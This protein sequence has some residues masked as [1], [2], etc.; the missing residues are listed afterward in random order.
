M[1][2]CMNV[3]VQYSVSLCLYMSLLH[4]Y[5]W[6]VGGG[7]WGGGREWGELFGGRHGCFDFKVGIMS[8]A[9][10]SSDRSR[11]AEMKTVAFQSFSLTPPPST[12][13]SPRFVSS[14]GASVIVICMC[15]CV[16][17]WR[18]R[19]RYHE[20]KVGQKSQAVYIYE[21]SS[22]CASFH[23]SPYSP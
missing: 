19:G 21:I 17:V 1:C 12:S 16:C 10:S 15:V 9:L 20:H 7:G 13:P 2:L 8:A 22:W 4:T 14:H 3:C 5:V 6:G 23:L 18:G 11:E